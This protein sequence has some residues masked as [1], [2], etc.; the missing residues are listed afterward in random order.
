MEHSNTYIVLS[1]NN[2]ESNHFLPNQFTGYLPNLYITETCSQKNLKNVSVVHNIEGN[3]NIDGENLLEPPVYSNNEVENLLEGYTWIKCSFCGDVFS[4]INL[5]MIHEKTHQNKNE[6]EC[7]KCN[8][9]FSK[10]N[11]YKKHIMTHLNDKTFNCAICNIGFNFENNYRVHMAIH[12]NSLVCP[13]CELSFQ[14]KASLKSHLA[15]H[16]V[17][18]LFSCP[19]CASEFYNMVE[20]KKHIK[21][22]SIQSNNKEGLICNY[23]KVEFE[24]PALLKEHIIC[25]MKVKKLVFN[26]RKTTKNH[27]KQRKLKHC[28]KVCGKSFPKLSLLERHLRIHNGERPFVCQICSKGFSQKGTL[29]IH[30][31]KH[32][33]IKP[34]SCTLCP[35]KFYQ[36][37][38]LKVHV[39]KTHTATSE[40]EKT[41]KCPECHSI[42]KRVA[43]L[44][45]HMRKFHA[46]TSPIT[47]T[48][49]IDQLKNLEKQLG[50]NNVESETGGS[51]KNPSVF[52]TSQKPGI[53]NVNKTE[54]Y[55]VY[56][57]IQKYEGP[58]KVYIC[59]YCDKAY[60]KPSDLIRHIRTHT[61]EK[62]FK[63][64]CGRSFALKSTL[65]G[66]MQ[67][68][69]GKKCSNCSKV[70]FSLKV[71][72]AHTRKHQADSIHKKN[73]EQEE[74]QNTE[75][76]LISPF[77]RKKVISDKPFKCQSCSSSFL[78][79]MSL[80]RHMRL[81]TGEKTHKCETCSRLFISAYTLNKHMK[82][83]T[84]L[85]NFSCDLCNKS[86][87][88]QSLLKRHY[89]THDET[90]PYECPY[91][92]KRYK[93]LVTCRKHI[94][95][96]GNF[97]EDQNGV[98][99][100]SNTLI[101][102]ENPSTNNSSNELSH[103][104]TLLR[105][106]T[107][108]VVFDDFL[109]I[110][111]ENREIINS[112]L[113][114][115]QTIDQPTTVTDSPSLLDSGQNQNLQT[116]LVS[117]P[118]L[119]NGEVLNNYFLSQ[120]DLQTNDAV[121]INSI[122]DNNEQPSIV[123][124][125]QNLNVNSLPNVENVM[126]AE[127]R[128]CD[129]LSENFD[130]VLSSTKTRSLLISNQI[131]NP[132][133]DSSETCIQNDIGDNFLSNNISLYPSTQINFDTPSELN[134]DAINVI[135]STGDT[136]RE[137]VNK[138]NSN[139]GCS[140][141]LLD[142]TT[143]TQEAV[144][145][146]MI[147]CMEC[148]KMFDSMEIYL[149]HICLKS[150][151]KKNYVSA[152]CEKLNEELNPKC[153]NGNIDADDV[154]D[155]S[156][157]TVKRFLKCVYCEKEFSNRGVYMKHVNSH[158]E[159]GLHMCKFCTKG[160]RKPS[161]LGRHLRT[162]TGEKPFACD[163]CDK[164]FS[165]KSTLEFHFKTHDPSAAKKFVCEVCNSFFTSLSSKKLHMHVHTG[166]KPHKCNY[167][168]QHFRT[169]AHRKCHEKKI[170]LNN[171]G[172]KVKQSKAK[173]ITNILAAAVDMAVNEAVSEHQ[174]SEQDDIS[175]Y[176]EIQMDFAEPPSDSVQIDQTLLQLQ[177][178]NI[179]L[180]EIDD[181]AC[182]ESVE[183]LVD[184]EDEYFVEN[185]SKNAD[186]NFVCHICQGEFETSDDLYKHVQ[187]HSK[188]FECD[189]CRSSFS[190]INE[191]TEHQ[192][193]HLASESYSC[194]LC[195]I[196]LAGVHMLKDHLRS[197]H[198]IV[199]TSSQL[200]F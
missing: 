171:Q 80:K 122:N 62:P 58:N 36:K 42:F 41:F 82:S 128:S 145:L 88:K 79:K 32:T 133:L 178:P 1:A 104:T 175:R 182:S 100:E 74:C 156:K 66:H 5:Y 129:D 37:C 86:F 132:T 159:N 169:I 94:D 117:C 123:L 34:F 164:K 136:F 103:K 113:E 144:N 18:E 185:I 158:Q 141:Q 190:S 137:D 125:I 105:E 177:S 63:C 25:H 181:L 9:S 48:T 43:S 186:E 163:Q 53:S 199:D 176:C 45:G 131:I 52:D 154:N 167:C 119:Q 148:K 146:N 110:Q 64:H 95:T 189:H 157:K 200:I 112:V 49:V 89:S 81:H 24:T 93:E 116:I 96:H 155:K 147:H 152:P 194:F 180:Q 77:K 127:A 85:K 183:D 68:H 134:S 188:K 161:D 140:L 26:G 114:S 166:A 138:T 101:A 14:R 3:A 72:R 39:Q 4:D 69:K 47:I 71:W 27:V 153:D 172:K 102:A 84:A 135:D 174:N 76:F 142:V 92:S 46:D 193:S 50:G 99:Q 111:Q 67:I 179:F 184:M 23:C 6:F 198:Q 118:E 130:P 107:N 28:C 33:G 139:A 121:I 54:N 44:N 160:F 83:H 61:K 97:S 151:L 187:L 124:N 22:H 65:Q 13:I 109:G 191:L 106:N 73:S 108:S 8:K 87:M 195:D 150:I 98:H 162:H 20:L 90:K 17:E 11:L 192:Q 143:E 21:T 126:G 91:C 51:N 29:Q 59:S 196:S 75:A 168:E 170:H 149:R 115:V 57:L 2:D 56:S 38:N 10:E 120:F 60:K 15:I 12:G 55:K 35:A 7:S 70:I 197:V 19:E 173:K 78:R 40:G 165:L 30:L 31:S 16:Q